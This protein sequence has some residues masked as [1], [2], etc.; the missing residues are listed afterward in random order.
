MSDFS[1]IEKNLTEVRYEIEKTAE[2][3]SRPMPR[4][5]AVT[6]SA[7]DEELLALVR[8][9]VP[10]IAEN[11]PQ[12]LVRR[13]ALIESTGLSP[14][15]HQIGH[16]QSNKAAKV[17]TLSPL[18]HSLAGES[19]LYELERVCAL[20]S[21]VARVLIEVNSAKEDQK[22][23]ILPEEVLP[24]YEKALACRHIK[25]EGLMTMGPVCQNPEEIRP[26]FRLTRELLDTLVS[27]YGEMENPILSMGMS[28]SYRVAIEEGSTLLRIGRR[29]FINE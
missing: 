19:L 10:D 5:V 4:L 2:R 9:G 7:T 15:Y 24:F 12:E 22:S 28:D 27:R 14:S 8:Y 1:Y 17:L 16:L 26:F 13:A 6:K 25:V 21:T 3:L 29:L 11:R 20:R 23:G 18:I